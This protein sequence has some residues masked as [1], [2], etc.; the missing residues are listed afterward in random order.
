MLIGMPHIRVV[1]S[2][3]T[4]MHCPMNLREDMSLVRPLVVVDTG[5]GIEASLL[6]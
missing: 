6:L 1:M 5:E 2:M 4:C 3:S